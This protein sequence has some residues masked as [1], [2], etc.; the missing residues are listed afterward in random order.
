MNT[1]QFIENDFNYIDLELPV[2]ACSFEIEKIKLKQ[3]SY[4]EALL[5][6]FFKNNPYYKCKFNELLALNKVGA[7]DTEILKE[8]M[9]NLLSNKKLFNT[10]SYYN[11]Q[12]E[13][14]I[15]LSPLGEKLVE[16]SYVLTRNSLT[17]KYTFYYDIATN[18]FLTENESKA[19][20]PEEQS[21]FYRKNYRFLRDYLQDDNNFPADQNFSQELPIPLDSHDNYSAAEQEND[22]TNKI[23]DGFYYAKQKLTRKKLTSR[24]L[25]NGLAL[26]GNSPKNSYH[27]DKKLAETFKNYSDDF[28]NAAQSKQKNQNTDVF[29]FSST[30]FKYLSWNTTELNSIL[31]QNK[32]II[33]IPEG[34]KAVIPC[35]DENKIIRISKQLFAPK[36]EFEFFLYDYDYMYSVSQSFYAAKEFKEYHGN[37]ISK[38][39][40]FQPFKFYLENPEINTSFMEILPIVE[41]TNSLTLFIQTIL[42]IKKIALQKLLLA[43]RFFKKNP[44][45]Q[46]FFK[47]YMQDIILKDIVQHGYNNLKN[48]LAMQRI[49]EIPEE[50]FLEIIQT[51]EFNV[52]IVHDNALSLLERK[53]LWYD[54]LCLHNFAHENI[55]KDILA[56]AP[57]INERKEISEHTLDILSDEFKQLIARSFSKTHSKY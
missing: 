37:K 23:K 14:S 54:E 1:Y 6:N 11:N 24:I 3:I 5:L 25:K 29:N 39:K 16:Q 18:A 8:V 33:F 22:I 57:V 52:V 10:S 4:H 26:A 34:T 56:L 31:S 20:L 49:A 28:I 35:S 55:K 46:S 38:E 2:I 27:L 9:Q 45:W 50:D 48:L 30:V 42:Q 36:S 47:R 43:N 15:G 21:F 40:F 32:Y 17:E 19:V 7:E 44:E 41:K 12:Q 13:M 53:C 51:A